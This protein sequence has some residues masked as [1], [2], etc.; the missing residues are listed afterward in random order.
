MFSGIPEEYNEKSY[1]SKE[2]LYQKLEC[3]PNQEDITIG[4]CHRIGPKVPGRNRDIIAHFPNENHKSK[5]IENKD[6]LPPGVQIHE[7]LPAEIS[8][9]KRELMPIFK[10]AKQCE[11]FR[12]SAK[13]KHDKLTIGR[14]TY[15]VRPVCNLQNLPPELQPSNACKVEDDNTYVF[16]GKH[17][18]LSNFYTCK[19]EIN[20]HVYHSSE[21]YLQE[22][23]AVVFNQ[24]NIAKQIKQAATPHECKK[25]SREIPNYT[26]SI[27][28][29]KAP[30]ILEEV[31]R[32]K[33]QQN[34]ICHKSLQDTNTK[35]LGEATKDNTWG[36]GLSL[37]DESTNKLNVTNW[38]GNN[39]M[40]RILEKIRDEPVI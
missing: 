5:I 8:A 38:T 29:E 16:F 25:L 31:L 21:Q 22:Q 23:K 24:M 20:G 3:M 34:P 15:T 28:V 6:K 35:V 17:H 33:L 14:T 11:K 18:P 13:L 39:I 27:W 7:D 4:R 37:L 36:T 1:R 12:D 10:L 30:I 19:I 9:R 32:V 26:H 40:G 2:I